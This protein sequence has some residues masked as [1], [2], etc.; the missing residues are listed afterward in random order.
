MIKSI[1]S[2]EFLNPNR[3]ILIC[4]RIPF[5][6]RFKFKMTN[7]LD[8]NFS[9]PIFVLEPSPLHS[10]NHKRPLPLSFATER[11]KSLFIISPKHS[12]SNNL[13]IRQYLHSISPSNNS[14]KNQRFPHT[15]GSQEAGVNH[16]CL[17]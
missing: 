6:S 4:K 14:L 5:S 13:F 7:S 12:K 2:K 10:I 1:S 11:V 9:L 8:Q 16:P 17:S 15:L 3:Q